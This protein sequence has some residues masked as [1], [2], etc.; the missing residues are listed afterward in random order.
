MT[1]P[2]PGAGKDIRRAGTC[3]I[4]SRGGHKGGIGAGA[5]LLEGQAEG[6]G[7]VH[8]GEEKILGRPY[9]SLPV[10]NGGLQES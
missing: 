1:A 8:A 4:E 2:A 3:W 5:P 7:A 9:G 6:A 10:P